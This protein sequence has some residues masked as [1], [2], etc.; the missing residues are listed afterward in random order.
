LAWTPPL[1]ALLTYEA[2]ATVGAVHS[3][4]MPVILPQDAHAAWLESDYAGACAL[5]A[6]YADEGMR[7]AERSADARLF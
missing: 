4:A 7:M 5:A 3:K 2:N 6:P 1:F